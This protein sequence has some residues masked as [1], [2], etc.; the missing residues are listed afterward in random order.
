M[1]YPALCLRFHVFY[2]CR[3]SLLLPH[4][5]FTVVSLPRFSSTPLHLSWYK[6]TYQVCRSRY[7]CVY[8]NV[9]LFHSMAYLPVS[10]FKLRLRFH[11]TMHL[12]RTLFVPLLATIGL[13]ATWKKKKYHEFKFA[14]TKEN[15]R[16]K[17][18]TN[19]KFICVVRGLTI[20]F[21][22]DEIYDRRE[23]FEKNKKKTSYIC[24]SFCNA[25]E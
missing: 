3:H 25:F 14:Q 1:N 22:K 7:L 19:H 5:T 21:V 20:G 12:Q 17:M 10:Y 6:N 15:R 8:S 24:I 18:L 16:C 9:R 4:A 2:F 13:F 11:A 23:S